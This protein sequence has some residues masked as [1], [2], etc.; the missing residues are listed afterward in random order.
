MFEMLYYQMGMLCRCHVLPQQ[1]AKYPH[2][3]DLAA[4]I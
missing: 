4:Q 3:V 1:Q 2:A